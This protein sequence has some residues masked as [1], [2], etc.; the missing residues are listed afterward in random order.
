MTAIYKT[1]KGKVRKQ[2]EDSGGIFTNKLGETLAVIADGMG[3]HNAGEVASQIAVNSL[4]EQ[5]AAVDNAMTPE[6]A[7]NWFLKNVEAVNQKILTRAQ[8]NMEYDG[9]GTTLVAAIC[10]DLFATIV[11]IGDS[12][13]Y[14]MNEAGFKQLTED[15]S[16]INELIKT[17]QISREE[18]ELHPRKNVLMKALGTEQAIDMD[19]TTITFEQ[20]DKIFL[21]SDGLT[22]KVSESEIETVLKNAHPLNEKVEILINLANQNGGEDNIS[23]AVVEHGS[24]IESRCEEC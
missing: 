12:R 18:A 1:D 22:N 7:G 8:E 2:N 3:G 6:Q 4:E 16:L 13:C 24:C 20:G 10:T 15:H 11:N 14:V 9:M 19:I 21:C 5:W 23:V 17:G